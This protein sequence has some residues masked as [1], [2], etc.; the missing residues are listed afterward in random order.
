MP[1][2]PLLQP[3]TFNCG[4]T[5]PNRVAMAPMVIKGG[6]EGG[7]VSEADLEFYRLRAEAAGLVI[8]GSAP[9]SRLGA[10]NSG[11][12]AIWS[13]NHVEGLS[14][15]A[16]V[17]K[18]KGAKAVVQIQHA[19]AKADLAWEKLHDCIAPTGRRFPAV[20]HPVREMTQED[21]ERVIG[22][23][24]EGAARAIRAGFDGVELH[25]AHGFLLQQ[26]FS[27]YSNWREDEWGGSFEKRLAFPLAVLRA[28]KEAALRENRPDFIVGYRVTPEEK[29]ANG[30]IGYGIRESL[31]LIDALCA[32]GLAYI[33]ATETS[34]GEVIRDRIAGRAA[35]VLVPEALSAEEAEE[36]LE[37]CDFPALGRALL[38]EPQFAK[39]V[40]EGRPGAIRR[41][42][43]GLSG[44]KAL[45]WPA[46]LIEWLTAPPPAGYHGKLP[47]GT[48][49]IKG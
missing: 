16:R 4:A 2:S 45:G 20:R 40:A 43:E 31:E 30:E 39:L 7:Y 26:F 44:A 8:T 22:E 28:V 29:H 15:L 24:A 9:V 23:Y 3:F 25:G 38:L 46:G 34:W 33:H 14:E 5:A 13:D 42:V 47:E 27:P 1:E 36:A 32:E 35:Y 41:R 48:A 18:A 11:Q 12:F 10:R 17:I 49:T 21:I 37:I 6:G 19:G